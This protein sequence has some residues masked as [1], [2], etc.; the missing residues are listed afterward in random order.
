M[1]WISSITEKEVLNS[2]PVQIPNAPK[3]QNTPQCIEESI[4]YNV[5]LGSS[6]NPDTRTLKLDLN[7]NIL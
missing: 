2:G 6:A 4:L 7:A 1:F 5:P 3:Q